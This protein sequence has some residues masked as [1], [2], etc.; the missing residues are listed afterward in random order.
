VSE[1]L[2]SP[3]LLSSCPLPSCQDLL[4]LEPNQYSLLKMRPLEAIRFE[5]AMI[6]IENEFGALDKHL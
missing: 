5:Q 3:P 2:L 1:A 6:Q 4:D